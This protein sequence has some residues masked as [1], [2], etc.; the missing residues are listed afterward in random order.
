MS[1]VKLD[2]TIG[3]WLAS[4]LRPSFCS[5]TFFTQWKYIS[6]PATPIRESVT[7]LRTYR[8]MAHFPGLLKTCPLVFSLFLGFD[9]LPGDISHMRIT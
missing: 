5:F 9:F 3:F 6:Y 8:A 1:E 7:R 2:V 4:R